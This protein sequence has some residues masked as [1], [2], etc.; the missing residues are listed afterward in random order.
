VAARP[1][2]LLS[3]GAAKAL[4]QGLQVEFERSNGLSLSAQFGAVGAM[5]EQLEGGRVAEE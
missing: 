5:R 1:L 3:A 4:V 2:H